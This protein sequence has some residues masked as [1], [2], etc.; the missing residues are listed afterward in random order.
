M[1]FFLL[2]KLDVLLVMLE[3]LSKCYSFYLLDLDLLIHQ[4]H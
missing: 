3:A 2:R 4:S 1:I